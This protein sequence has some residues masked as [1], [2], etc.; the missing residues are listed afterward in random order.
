MEQTEVGVTTTTVIL[1]L[2]GKY[3]DNKNQTR[4]CDARIESILLDVNERMITG[5]SW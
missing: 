5:S 2:F 3:V 1:K 4:C